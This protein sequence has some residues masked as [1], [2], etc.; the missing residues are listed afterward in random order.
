MKKNK[1]IQ[2]CVIER[3]P[4]KIEWHTRT[5]LI[6]PINSWITIKYFNESVVGILDPEDDETDKDELV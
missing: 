2:T 3:V 5:D 6:V 1:T 4:V